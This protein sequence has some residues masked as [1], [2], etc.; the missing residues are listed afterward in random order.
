[1]KKKPIYLWVLLILSALISAGSLFGVLTPLPS[2]E[3]LRASEP[4]AGGVNA[5]QVEDT[6]NYTYKVAEASHSIFNVALVVLSAILVVVAI[7]FLVRK[8]LQYANYTYVGYVLLA[9]IGSIYSYVTLQDAVQLVQDE[10]MRLGISIGSK[11]VSILYIVIN[12]LF[13]ALVFYKIWR[14]QKALAEEEEA[15]NLA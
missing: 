10:S 15:E 12:V 14:Q 4:Q 6:L 8:N 13:L 7:V 9:I 11:A 2:K 5:Q 3:V 1:M